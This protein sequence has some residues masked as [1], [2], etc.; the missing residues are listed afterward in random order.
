MEEKDKYSET[1]RNVCYEHVDSGGGMVLYMIFDKNIKSVDIILKSFH[2][3]GEPTLEPMSDWEKHSA[4]KGHWHVG[5][6]CLSMKD[7][8]FLYKKSKELFSLVNEVREN[9]RNFNK[10][11]F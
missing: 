11:E 2:N 10:G 1:D 9:D 4:D 7:I 5:Y 3:S 8:E 6:T